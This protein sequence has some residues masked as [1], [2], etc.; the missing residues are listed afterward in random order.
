MACR[1]IARA[2]SRRR[3][4]VLRG[5]PDSRAVPCADR[6]LAARPRLCQPPAIVA[7][8][9]QGADCHNLGGRC[10]PASGDHR[11]L[12][13]NARSTTAIARTVVHGAIPEAAAAMRGGSQGKAAAGGVEPG[14]TGGKSQATI[15]S[16][17]QS[18]YAAGLPPITP[19]GFVRCLT[20]QARSSTPNAALE[21]AWPRRCRRR[22]WSSRVSTGSTWRHSHRG[23]C[24]CHPGGCE[25][26]NTLPEGLDWNSIAPARWLTIGSSPIRRRVQP[27]ST[28]Q[29]PGC[30]LFEQLG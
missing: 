19:G 14:I 10:E 5:G 18:G 30:P 2:A 25:S 23:P 22:V 21:P 8:G 11:H 24:R 1:L 28:G 13:R 16:V 3:R 17:E 12:P 15:S 20:E 9:P 27:P 6:S 26:L 4:P 29:R 7:A